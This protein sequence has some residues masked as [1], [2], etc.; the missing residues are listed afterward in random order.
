MNVLLAEGLNLGLSK[1]AGASNSHG[2]WQLQR[3]SQWHIVSDAINRALAAV[4]DAQADLP[5]AHIWGL[6][7]TA[8]SDGQF[9]PTTRQGDGHELDQCEIQQ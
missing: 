9:F 1:M 8:S 2:Y 7:E 5:M 3:I 6:G 4:I